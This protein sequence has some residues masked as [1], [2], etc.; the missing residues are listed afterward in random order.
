MH[1]VLALCAKHDLVLQTCYLSPQESIALIKEAKAVKIQ[2]IVCTHAD[3]D[4]IN[5]SVDGQKEP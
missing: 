3:Y 1:E 2:K 4:R 5:M